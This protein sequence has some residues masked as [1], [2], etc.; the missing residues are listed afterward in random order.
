LRHRVGETNIGHLDV[1]A[2][3]AGLIKTALALKHRKIPASLHYKSS[4]SEIDFANTPFYVNAELSDWPA[5]TTPRRAGVSSFGSGGTNAHVLLEEAPALEPSAAARS[6][7]LI[8]LSAKTV[9]ALDRTTKDLAEHLASHPELNLGDVVHTLQCG[10]SAFAHR[11]MVVCRDLADGADALRSMNPK[12]VV[13]NHNEHQAPSIAFMFPGQGAQ[14][15]N[16]GRGLYEESS[17]FRNQVAE[18]AESIAAKLGLDIRTVLYPAA[19]HRERAEQLLSQASITQPALFVV[20]YALAKLWIEWGIEPSFV[21]GHSLGEYVAACLAG[22][23]SRDDALNLVVERA[24]LVQTLPAGAMLAIRLPASRVEG[25][26]SKEHSIAAINSPTL[27][28]VSGVVEAIQTL[29]NELA[30]E[31]IPCRR[32]VTSH[33]FHSAM[34]DPIMPPF[35]EIMRGIRLGEPRLPWV[36]TLTG[37]IIT[38]AEAM[39]PEYWVRQLREPVHFADSVGVLLND[40]VHALLEVGPGQGLATLARQHPSKR[41]D[42][43]IS[44]SLLSSQTAGGDLAGMLNSL[45]RLWLAG[46]EVD[47]SRVDDEKRR[48]RVALPTYPFDSKR[49]WPSARRLAGAE[50]NPPPEAWNG[51]ISLPVVA[52]PVAAMIAEPND[53][54]AF[55]DLNGVAPTPCHR[56]DVLERLQ[57]L[58]SEI[59]GIAAEDLL[60]RASFLELGLDSLLLTQASAAL[61]KRFGVKVPFRQLLEELSSLEALADHLAASIPQSEKVHKRVARPPICNQRE[62]NDQPSVVGSPAVFGALPADLFS[63]EQIANPDGTALE[64][65]FA[66]QLDLMQ[67]QLDMLKTSGGVNPGG[68]I[69]VSSAPKASSSKIEPIATLAAAGEVGRR[70]TGEKG[71]GPYKPIPDGKQHQLTE[72]QQQYLND[73]IARYTALTRKSKILTA[74]HRPHLADPRTVAGFRSAWKELIYPVVTE[75]SAGSK[76]WDV[77]GNEYIDLT[78]GFGAILFGHGPEFVTTAIQE[79][80]KKGM[81]I[82]P[83][84]PLA[85][86]VAALLCELTGMERAA[87]CN[88][89]SEAVLAALRIA[90]TVTGRDKIAMFTGDYHGIFDEVVVRAVGG[91]KSRPAAPGIPPSMADNV[92]VLEYGDPASLAILRDQAH[93]LAAVIV[94]PVQSRRLDLQPKEFLRELRELTARAGTALIFDEIVTGF[95]SHLGGAQAIFG[96]RADIATYGKVIGGGLPIGIVAGKAEFMDTLDGGPWMFGDDSAPEVG[97]TFF[98]GTFMRHPLA[99]AATKACLTHLKEKSPE[100]QERLSHRTKQLV[101][102]L[103]A[104]A[105]ELQIPVRIT[106]FSS[107]FAF[108]FPPELPLASLFYP[109][110]RA[111]GIHIWEGRLGILTTA[112]TDQDIDRI[113][114]AFRDCLAEMQHAEFLPIAAVGENSDDRADADEN[115]AD[116]VIAATDGQREIWLAAQM[117]DDASRAFT[118]C[119][120]VELRGPL[121]IVALRHVIQEL[122]TRHD[123]LRMTYSDDGETLSVAPQVEIDLPVVDLGTLNLEERSERL[124]QIITEQRTKT[125]DLS[126]EFM[127]RGAV[128]RMAADHHVLVMTTHHAAVDGWSFGVLLAEL[129]RLYSAQCRSEVPGLP[130]APQFATYARHEIAARRSEEWNATEKFWL[131]Q[132]TSLPPPLE[133][134]LDRPRA[135]VKSYLARRRHVVL[136]SACGRELRRFAAQR[137]ATLFSTLLAAFNVLLHRLSGQ[138]DIVVGI[139]VAGQLAGDTP[140]LVG[141][142][143]NFLPLRHR[144]DANRSFTTYLSAVKNLVLDAHDHQNYTYGSLLRKLKLPRDGGRAPLMSASFNLDPAIEK[145]FLDGLDVEVEIQE[146]S[147]INFDCS[148]NIVDGG[149]DLSINWQYNADL[150]DDETIESWLGHYQTLLAEITA[151]PKRS[152]AD[153]PLLTDAERHRLLVEWNDTHREYPEGRCLHQLFEEQVTRTPEVVAVVI[154]D[155]Q[156]TYGELNRQANQLA[157][158]LRKLG[159]GRDILVGLCL[160]RSLDLVVACLAILKAGGAYVPLDSEY[161]KDRLA[162]MIKDS[163]APVL[164][165]QHHL[166]EKL[167]V[168]SSRILC[169]DTDCKAI[170]KESGDNPVNFSTPE[171]LAYV[172]YTSGS[173]GNP[174][175]VMVSHSAIVN[176]MLW[177]QETF[178]LNETDRVLQKTP[179][180]FDASVW[181]CYAPLLVGARLVMARPGGNQDGGYL[182]KLIGEQKITALKVVP[183][184]LR[185]LLDEPALSDA[186]SLRRVFC[187]GE[188][189]TIELQQKFHTRLTAELWNLY[190]PTETT[191][192]VIFYECQRDARSDLVPIGRPIA[193]TEVYILDSELRPTAVGLAGE[194]YVGGSS[195]ARGY[196][197]RPDLTAEKFVRNPFSNDPGARLYRTGDLVRYRSDGNIVYLGRIDNQIKLRGFRIEPGEIEAILSEL[198]A[199]RAAIVIAREDTAGNKRL[200]A[201]LVMKVGSTIA[202]ND[203]RIYLKKKLPQY[204]MPAAFVVLPRLP[205]TA[206]G[207][208]DRRALPAPDNPTLS[209]N[210]PCVAPRNDVERLIERIWCDVLGIDRLGI[211]ENF[212]DIGGH[213]IL[214]TRAMARLRQECRIDLPLRVLFECPTIAELGARVL[215]E[216]RANDAAAAKAD[217]SF[218]HLFELKSGD[219]KKPVFFLPGGIGGDEEFLVYARFLHHV[220]TDHKFYGMR[221]RSASGTVECQSSVAQMAADYIREIQKLQPRGPYSIV[222]NCT[223]GIVAYEIARQLEAQGQKIALLALMDTNRPSLSLYLSYRWKR[224][225]DIKMLIAPWHR[226]K[227]SYYMTRARYHGRKICGL[228]WHEVLPYS[229]SRLATALQAMQQSHP[230]KMVEPDRDVD[231]PTRCRPAIQATYE[232]ALRRYRP[233]LLH[234]RMTLIVNQEAHRRNPDLGWSDLV[235]EGIEIYKARGDHES[236]IREHVQAVA[237]QLESILAKSGI[238]PPGHVGN[239]AIAQEASTNSVEYSLG[240]SQSIRRRLRL[241]FRHNRVLHGAGERI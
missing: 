31:K 131:D 238:D 47:W 134:P 96:V 126:R 186:T 144:I 176:F 7:E 190:G 106:H 133:L 139:S 105:N 59:S 185:M 192:D 48:L 92:I 202:E 128:I 78:N 207:K 175:G 79:Q 182:A 65:I 66:R 224:L 171:S 80:I 165:T 44:L 173:T 127:L 156:L 168:Q 84:S 184:L 210:A 30:T 226:F 193:N 178:P 71:F 4:Q 129:G 170:G 104:H 135:N 124:A 214:A 241:C 137:G 146:R 232:R 42:Q 167:P 116:S 10:R 63:L 212:F 113:L 117:S 223:G 6:A 60:P 89:G 211:E 50:K 148:L 24:R 97:M 17:F 54:S 237:E 64:R 181:E 115:G 206:N 191:V 112:H 233:G 3:V 209:A 70:P 77:D 86:E 123:S 69:A 215:A 163:R 29:E 34:L 83:Q 197:N 88:T 143:V 161:P 8:V 183:S 103:L 219:P 220:D 230:H 37:A 19:A 149:E 125:F 198:Q 35:R 51:K 179:I 227:H 98:A 140:D 41:P 200:V 221:S 43:E 33:A 36:S 122:V 22:V 40:E 58:F 162:Y 93:E 49:F 27:T 218:S 158:H 21:V 150:F 102:G 189:L 114:V 155:Q 108:E 142:C 154:D 240:W 62:M 107:L 172:I 14:Y 87:F 67:Q 231:V 188:A 2:G 38:V 217:T 196:L 121:Q 72:R 152:L 159:V 39:D 222:G 1:A 132:F 130:P 81:E 56:E 153:L 55:H 26:L 180:S 82:G 208:L 138:D 194:L 25:R 205:L 195:L 95:R 141:H 91:T 23:F 203:L 73:F 187:G 225:G 76:L 75:R 169:L 28:V 57:T 234:G 110:M 16:M 204:M 199:V 235:S 68:N 18:C 45:G 229:R 119:L 147:A 52:S 151:D 12:R 85:G 109:M 213:S 74:E 216:L 177:T 236:Y 20:E 164:L 100:L 11:R 157:H 32:L 160:E 120:T 145:P 53:V 94:E 228:R 13:T 111:R 15:V 136:P 118:D 99:L 174:K 5:G 201:Y 166:V 90:R 9:E 101:D 46:A 239:Q 61:L